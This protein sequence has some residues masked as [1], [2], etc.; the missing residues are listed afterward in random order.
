MTTTATAV[1]STRG[2]ARWDAGHPWIYRSDVIERPTVAAGA[3]VVKDVP[4]KTIV[5][6]VPARTIRAVEEF[7]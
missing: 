3:V 6:G 7:R 1:V 4:A 2:A 5:G